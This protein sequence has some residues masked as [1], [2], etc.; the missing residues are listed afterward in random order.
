MKIS[1]KIDYACRALLELSHHWPSRTPL[2][3]SEIAKR[4]HIPMKFLVHILI[5]LKDLGYV[6]SIRGKSGGYFLSQS[7][8]NIKLSQVIKNFGGLWENSV[9]DGKSQ[10]HVMD[11]VWRELNENVCQ[12]IDEFDFEKISSRARTKEKAVSFEI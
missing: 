3:V 11:S 9:G 7:P 5:S 8:K 1:A 12:C 2:H 10:R 4:Q 6:E